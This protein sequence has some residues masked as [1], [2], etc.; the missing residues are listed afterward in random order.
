MVVVVGLGVDIVGR[1]WEAEVMV[2]GGE[3]IG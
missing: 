2:G 1:Y 3:E